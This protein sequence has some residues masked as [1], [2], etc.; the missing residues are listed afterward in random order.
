M[1]R[2]AADAPLRAET[3]LTLLFLGR[4]LNDDQ[5]YTRES[6][7]HDLNNY[8]YECESYPIQSRQNDQHGDIEGTLFDYGSQIHQ[9][10]TEFEEGYSFADNGNVHQGKTYKNEQF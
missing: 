10:P 9:Q 5:T 8:S 2:K 6:Q 3:L 4:G 7:Y 1:L